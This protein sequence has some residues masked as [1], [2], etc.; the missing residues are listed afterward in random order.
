V[1]AKFFFFTD[2]G[3]LAPQ[4]AAQAFGP[5]GTSGGKDQFRVTDIHTSVSP[6]SAYAVCRGHIC[7]QAV[8]GSQNQILSLNLILRPLEQAPFDFPYVEYF[9]YRNIQFSSLVDSS[10]DL[11]LGA[12]GSSPSQNDLIAFIRAKVLKLPAPESSTRGGKYIG[13]DRASSAGAGVFAD[14][15]P[16]DH[17]FR[18]PG[19]AELPVVEAGW[20]LGEF[21]GGAFGFEVVVQTYGAQPKL[22][23]A[24]KD[25]AVMIEADKI[26]PSDAASDKY[27]SRLARETIGC[28]VDPCA[29]WGMFFYGGLRFRNP[30][31]PDDSKLVKRKPVCDKLFAANGTFKN[32]GRV[33]LNVRN[34][35]GYSYNFYLNY[36]DAGENSL[37]IGATAG[38]LVL[39][40]YGV[41][42]WPVH[43]EDGLPGS[44]FSFQLRVDN[45][46]APV[47]F[48]HQV[49]SNSPGGKRF[50]DKDELLESTNSGWTTPITFRTPTESGSR[51]PWCFVAHYLRGQDGSGS[52]APAMGVFDTTS[53]Q[54]GPIGDR[55]IAAHGQLWPSGSGI[56]ITSAADYERSFVSDKVLRHDG[57]TK[58]D[59]TDPTRSLSYERVGE[60]IYILQKGLG[61]NVGQD[62]VTILQRR[63]Y[64]R[65]RDFGGSWSASKS[66]ETM[67]ASQGLLFKLLSGQSLSA[68]IFKTLNVGS[69]PAVTVPTFEE[70]QSDTAVKK[71]LFDF[72]TLCLSKAAF[73]PAVIASNPCSPNPGAGEIHAIF[74]SLAVPTAIL[75]H[76]T[77]YK[78]A[79][80]GWDGQS[81]VSS[82]ANTLIAIYSADGVFF[83]S[84]DFDH[85]G[86]INLAFAYTMTPEE[87]WLSRLWNDV[88]AKD[89]MGLNESDRMGALVDG[90][91]FAVLE[92]S[93]ISSDPEGELLA[94][95]E[96]YAPQIWNRAV[97]LVQDTG[98][99]DS[100]EWSDRV[101]YCARAKM[102]LSLKNHAYVL[103]N[104]G[105][106]T[107]L[108]QR[109]E[110]LSR[111]YA[112]LVFSTAANQKRIIVTGFDPYGSSKIVKTNPSGK[113][114]LYFAQHAAWKC[115]LAQS[116]NNDLFIRTCIFPNRYRDFDGGI[117][118]GIIGSAIDLAKTGNSPVAVVCTCSLDPFIKYLITGVQLQDGTTV[119]NINSFS[120][121]HLRIDRFAGK[122]RGGDEDNGVAKSTLLDDRT[123]P[124]WTDKKE[125]YETKLRVI[126]PSN[127]DTLIKYDDLVVKLRYNE[128]LRYR[129]AGGY[130]PPK[131]D[132]VSER[133][134]DNASAITISLSSGTVPQTI[135]LAVEGSGGNYFS[136]EIF[137]RVSNFLQSVQGTSGS[138]IRNGHIHVPDLGAYWAV[139]ATAGASST[140]VGTVTLADL[141]IS[142]LAVLDG[143]S[144][145]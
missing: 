105:T 145:P 4:T 8:R 19:G 123:L 127:T 68:P 93:G 130:H 50:I 78:V 99:S 70:L 129:D 52:T 107:M 96:T 136:N 40:K 133:L 1:G 15:K 91:C 76:C 108:I 94:L 35:T 88:I 51:P 120:D 125:F 5:A 44:E 98:P 97:D 61:T 31:Q 47:V 64:E 102:E 48:L 144:G 37:Q 132:T 85:N 81:I 23:W 114:A 57:A 7:V 14:T 101:L 6:A 104:P 28:F 18:Y 20:K 139:P 124:V 143:V 71:E 118:E 80:R 77:S 113:L 90:F 25:A 75:A 89:K 17:L 100:L 10:G 86:L 87:E 141:A 54:F 117:V 67:P 42:D 55:V 126:F 38:N 32:Q 83:F 82:P 27:R 110:E 73:E 49:G 111:N 26:G 131:R 63:Q 128:W 115:T 122:C 62:S 92:V 103:A 59:P 109:F 43:F 79:W 12:E 119:S 13:L 21:T 3:L 33:Y 34:E 142:V 138:S 36:Q 56:A 140:L 30:G 112:N 134:Q 16:I 106:K 24:R 137:Y 45:N 60:T 41:G 72:T 74:L 22:G 2:P 29:F 11:N 135:V 116:H 84:P 46:P 9:L 65:R 58:V 121:L 66:I 69:G 53:L 39:K 95:V